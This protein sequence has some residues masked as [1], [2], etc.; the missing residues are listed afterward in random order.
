MDEERA[1]RLENYRKRQQKIKEMNEKEKDKSKR[2]MEK[3]KK[4]RTQIKQVEKKRQLLEDARD[5]EL[6]KFL[7]EENGENIDEI[8]LNALGIDKEEIKE[9]NDSEVKYE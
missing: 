5:M 9:E 2:L 7:R 3:I 8:L 4:Q 1:K 6:I